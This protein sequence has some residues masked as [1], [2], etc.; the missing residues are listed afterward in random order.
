MTEKKTDQDHM[1]NEPPQAAPTANQAT[2]GQLATKG[3]EPVSAF[4]NTKASPDQTAKERARILSRAVAGSNTVTGQERARVLGESS[5]PTGED[6]G[7]KNK[8]AGEIRPDFYA[9]PS[10]KHKPQGAQAKSANLAV[11]GTIPVGTAPSPSGPVPADVQYTSA[12]G[13]KF[14]T[15]PVTGRQ[16]DTSKPVP[17]SLIDQMDGVTL[18]AV[19]H[20]RGYQIPMAGTR[21]VRQLFRQAEAKRFDKKSTSS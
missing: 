19:G 4:S 12:V 21:T 1:A 10:S 20:D 7:S 18:R 8:I 2:A 13:P 3:Q 14:Q 5:V 11:N 6:R 15:K 9:G 17:D 16:L